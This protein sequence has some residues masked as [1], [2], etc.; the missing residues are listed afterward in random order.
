MFRAKQTVWSCLDQTLPQLKAHSGTALSNVRIPQIVRQRFQ[1]GI[2][3]TRYGGGLLTGSPQGVGDFRWLTG[4]GA[5]FQSL[6]KANV[7]H[8]ICV[9][10]F[11]GVFFFP[12]F[13]F[14]Y[15]PLKF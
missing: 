1:R 5:D 8:T 12:S 9:D 11:N 13:F 10:L 14:H 3:T 2:R 4:E 7:A 6:K 15:F